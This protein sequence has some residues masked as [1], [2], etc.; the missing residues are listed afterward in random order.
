MRAGAIAIGKGRNDQVPLGD[1]VHF[2]ADLFNHPDEF[3]ADR[4]WLVRRL[5]AVV[6]EVRPADAAQHDPN[7]RVR[8]SGDHWVRPLADL[9]VMRS[10]VDGRTHGYAPSIGGA[11]AYSA[12]VTCGPQIAALPSSSTSSIARCAMNRVGA[13]P[14]Q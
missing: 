1:A 3:M 8:R 10:A 6:P 2:V 9:D 5:P 12:S 7:D 13:A 11:A 14:C 4:A